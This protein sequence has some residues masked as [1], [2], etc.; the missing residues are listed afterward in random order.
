MPVM[1]HSRWWNKSRGR[2]RST[3]PY[4]RLSSAE[5]VAAGRGCRYARICAI[6]DM[7]PKSGG[8]APSSR[9]AN[10]IERGLCDRVQRRD[11]SVPASVRWG[12]LS[13]GF[14]DQLSRVSMLAHNPC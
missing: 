9:R 1:S 14:G 12:G 11:K 13:A 10:A 7:A 4:R 6:A 3:G 5:A 8:A 2:L